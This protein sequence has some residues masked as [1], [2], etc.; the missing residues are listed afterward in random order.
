[1]PARFSIKIRRIERPYEEDFNA[2][3]SWLCNSLGLGSKNACYAHRILT[4]I[5]KAERGITSTELS[6]RLN[7]SRGAV[8]HQLNKL[9]ECGLIV[10]QGR[11]YK[12][13]ASTMERTLE[14]IYE[15]IERMFAKLMKIAERIDKELENI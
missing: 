3:I 13:R 5:L 2:H 11:F 1:M 14:E 7:K 8:I 15:D 4:H 6:K 9:I 12:L 10:K